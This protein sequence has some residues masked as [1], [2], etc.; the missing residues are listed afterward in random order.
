MD[1]I[2]EIYAEMTMM[3]KN[4]ARQAA[5]LYAIAQELNK[6]RYCMYGDAGMQ[7]D[8]IED[9]FQMYGMEIEDIDPR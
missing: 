8:V 6:I 4:M 5:A 3:N 2:D 7:D 1:T 9:T